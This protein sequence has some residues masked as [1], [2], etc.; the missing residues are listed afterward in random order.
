MTINAARIKNLGTPRWL[1]ANTTI[2]ESKS[3]I[4]KVVSK[5]ASLICLK[6]I[7]DRCDRIFVIS[8]TDIE[9]AEG[10]IL[11]TNDSTNLLS[12]TMMLT[13]LT[14]SDNEIVAIDWLLADGTRLC[15]GTS[16][17]CRYTF[18]NYGN[19]SIIATIRLANKSS[20]PIAGSLTI[21]EPLIIA[22]HAEIYDQ[23][24]RL[25]NTIDTLDPTLGAYV[26][27]D[28]SVPAKITLDARDVVTENPGYSIRD[29]I[30]RISDGK[31][32]IEKVGDRVSFE[33]PRT[34]RYTIMANYTFVKNIVTSD[35]D[36]RTSSDMII[37]D[38]ERKSLDPIIKLQQSSDYVPAKITVDASSSQSKNGT[39]KKF[40][41]DFGEGRPPIE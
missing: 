28:I 22:R 33:V 2:E 8:D 35:S 9:R 38:L 19:K 34:Q 7:T 30:W 5:T 20:Y 16:L 10:S 23:D 39:I 6:V 26:I 25:L 40:I 32:T 31:Q 1:E 11:F 21:N 12:S 17:E 4:T 24:E 29:I 41:F 37:L 15:S 13:G 3:S 36:I 27:R 14:L 18:P